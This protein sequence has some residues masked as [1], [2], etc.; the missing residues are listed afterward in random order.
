MNAV[1]VAAGEGKRMR[2][3]LPK[4]FLSLAGRPLILHTLGRFA[5]SSVRKVILV[6]AE[7]ELSRCRGLVE[8]DPRLRGLEVVF[9]AGGVRRQD[10]VRSGLSRL[11]PDCEAVVIHDGVRPFISPELIDICIEIASREGAVVVGVPVKDTI[12]LVRADLRVAETPSRNS[13]WEIQTPQVFRSEIILEAYN[14][15]QREATEATDD[16]TLVE[17]LGREVTVVAGEAT[18]IKITL[19]QDLLLAEAMIREGWI[20]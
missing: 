18:N 6:A 14:R 11:D 16:A 19:P 5:S 17:R 20:S 13:L 8:S 4:P 3:R 15:A 9:Q 2:G 10:S 1:I 12:K 7:T